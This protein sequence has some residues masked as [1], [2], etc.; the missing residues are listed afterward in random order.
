MDS[1]CYA[2]RP[3]TIDHVAFLYIIIAE[4]IDFFQMFNYYKQLTILLKNDILIL[5]IYDI[6]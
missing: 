1:K 5:Y 2:T 6:A 4:E 3:V